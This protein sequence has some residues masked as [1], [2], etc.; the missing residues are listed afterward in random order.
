[1]SLPLLIMLIACFAEQL[2]RS[3]IDKKATPWRE[4]IFN[5]NSG[6]AVLWIFRGL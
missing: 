1:M 4:V 6:H 3:K 5:L 2:I